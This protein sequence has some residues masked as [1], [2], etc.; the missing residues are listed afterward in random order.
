MEHEFASKIRFTLK[1]FIYTVNGPPPFIH[2]TEIKDQE[3]YMLILSSPSPLS[4]KHL[5]SPHKIKLWFL[6]GEKSTSPTSHPSIYKVHRKR[7]KIPLTLQ[8][9]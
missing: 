4:L 3:I 6:R 1:K 2:P 9:R 8:L 5:A 7:Q